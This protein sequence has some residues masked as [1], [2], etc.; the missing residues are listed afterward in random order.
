MDGLLETSHLARLGNRQKYPRSSAPNF[1]GLHQLSNLIPCHLVSNLARKTGE[2]K[3]LT[4]PELNA[5][6]ASKRA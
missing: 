4:I 5:R 2:A 3:F 6:L 1:S